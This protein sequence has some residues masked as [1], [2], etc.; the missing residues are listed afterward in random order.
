MRNVSPALQISFTEEHLLDIEENGNAFTLAE[1]LR[2]RKTR[3]SLDARE[4]PG[5]EVFTWGS[6]VNST[7]GHKADTSKGVPERV[8]CEAD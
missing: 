4:A 8:V 6:N 7:L 5:G 3:E 1:Q 2:R